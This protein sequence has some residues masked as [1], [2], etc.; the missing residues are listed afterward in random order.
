MTLPRYHGIHAGR[1][2]A[3]YSPGWQ[4]AVGWSW[5]RLAL[6]VGWGWDTDCP[7]RPWPVTYRE[8]APGGSQVRGIVWCG[9]FVAVGRL[10]AGPGKGL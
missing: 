4:I 8:R 6:V 1:V 10:E 7:L 5:P 9:L 2:P 3:P